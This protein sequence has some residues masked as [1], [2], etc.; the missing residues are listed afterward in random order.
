M[1]WDR[2]GNVVIA[3]LPRRAGPWFVIKPIKTVLR[4]AATPLAHGVGVFAKS[5]ADLLVLKAGG[6]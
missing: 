2:L 1:A 3:D 5:R 4:K 6:S